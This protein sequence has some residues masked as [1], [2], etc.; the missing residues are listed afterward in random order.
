MVGIQIDPENPPGAQLTLAP[1]PAPSEGPGGVQIPTAPI[2]IEA[3]V[4]AHRPPPGDPFGPLG[5]A[6]SKSHRRSD[7]EVGAEF[8]RPGRREP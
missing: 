3:N 8:P 7:H 1:A 6:V 2:R 5:A 4:V